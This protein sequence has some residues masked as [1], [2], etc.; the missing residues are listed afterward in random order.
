MAKCVICKKNLAVVF[1]TRFENGQRV[2]EGL[3]LKC[4]YKTG[5]G[6]MDEL[7]SKAGITDSNIDELTDRMNQV[8]SQVDGQSPENLFQSLLSGNFDLSA[9]SSNFDP[10]LSDGDDST[11]KSSELQPAS[12]GQDSNEVSDMRSPS[13]EGD[14]APSPRPEKRRKFLDQFGTNLTSKALDGRIDRIIGRDKELARV[15]QILN[16]RAKNNPVLLGEPGVG[17]TAIAEGL[18]VKIANREVPVKLLHQEVY[19]LDMTAMVAGTQFRGQFESR[20][21]GVVD[22]ARKAGNI[23]LVIDELH[24]IMGAGD[25]EGAMNAANILKP[26]LA[27]GEIR[28]LGSTT[29][30]EYRRFIEKDS[31]LERRFQKVIVEEP[32]PAESVEI[33]KGVRDYYEVHHHVTYSDEVVEL[34][35]RMAD[36]Y[37]TDRFL[38]DKA[39]DLLDE[40]GSH[41]N[42]HNEVIIK[43]DDDRRAL[44]TLKRDQE[45]LE[46]QIA[47]SPDDVSMYEREAELRSKVLRLEDELQKLEAEARPTEITTEDIAR[48]VEM[49]TGIPVQR[50]NESETEKLVKLEDRLHQRVIGQQQAVSALARAIRRNRAGFGKKR[51]PASF[52]FVGPTGVGKTELVKALAEALFETE[53]AMV[54]LDMSEF[55]E[56]H[57]VS[58]LIGSPPGYVG[59]DDGGQLTEKIRRKPYSVILLDEIEKAHADVFNILLQILDDGRLTDSHGRLVSFEN[60]VIVMTSNAGT[61][62]KA[63]AFGFGAEGYVALESRVQSVLKEMFRPEFLNR[64]DEIV[65]FSELSKDEIRQ[66]V[67]LMLKEVSGHLSEKGLQ[68]VVTDA[69]KDYL[70]EK[71][72]DPKYGARPL[73]KT[74]QRLLEDPLADLV[75][76]GHLKNASGVSADYKDGQIKLDWI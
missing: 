5:L 15:V 25:A 74:I 48:V 46:N 31:A 4:A 75:L 10:E 24:N 2:N 49:W 33:L 73:R 40:A 23:I 70:A 42:L 65:V 21:K 39:I 62:L 37:I 29:L 47:N 6:G 54:R 27:K 7:F 55:M 61:T 63:N 56:P 52:I 68:F 64:V 18:A 22:E 43:I 44:Q 53:D 60:T 71:G 1:T 16:R 17:K 34:A 3:C 11:E 66:I 45:A 30:D 69:A 12:V 76:A 59:Y 50:I 57:T 32:S 67:D 35:V 41:C 20:M 51:K 19:L 38:P 9:I 36:R 72:Y 14:P 28:V 26:A 58:K 13:R 8:M